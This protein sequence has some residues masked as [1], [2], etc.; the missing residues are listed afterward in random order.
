[1]CAAL[2]FARLPERIEQFGGDGVLIIPPGDVDESLVVPDL[3][4]GLRMALRE[5]NE[6]LIPSARLRLRFALARGL[7]V[8]GSAGFAGD[9][10][11]ACFR[12]LDSPPVRTA[13]DTLPR[14]ELATIISEGLFNDVVRHGFAGLRPEEFRKVRCEVPG[15]RFSEVARLCVTMRTDLPGMSGDTPEIP[16]L[17][18]S[19]G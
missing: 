12:L 4:Y 15:K 19:R 3:L 16:H 10:V 9:T 17:R 1:M 7:V 2:R 18:T 6:P 5:K 8:H 11:I 13:L 14:A